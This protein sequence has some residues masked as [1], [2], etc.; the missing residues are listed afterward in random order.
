MGG[1][2]DQFRIHFLQEIALWADWEINFV[3][4]GALTTECAVP[5]G[6][7]VHGAL[8]LGAEA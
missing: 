5:P 4:E 6:I 8:G 3:D 2:G 1:L 7:R